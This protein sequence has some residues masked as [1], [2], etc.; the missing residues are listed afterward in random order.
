ML[1]PLNLF[2]Q[3]VQD[4]NSDEEDMNL[5]LA[6]LSEKEKSKQNKQ[7][8]NDMNKAKEKENSRHYFLIKMYTCN[9]HMLKS[10]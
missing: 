7:N 1:H 8:V 5:T 4:T 3:N 10:L 6:T 2:S 9:V